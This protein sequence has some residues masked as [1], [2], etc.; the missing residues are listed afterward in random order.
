M[1]NVIYVECHLCCVTYKPLI[2]SV[3][4]LSVVAPSDLHCKQIS[5]I[6]LPRLLPDKLNIGLTKGSSILVQAYG[7]NLW[8]SD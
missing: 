3:I 7:A 6:I 5:N 1:P 2:L 4:V 8:L